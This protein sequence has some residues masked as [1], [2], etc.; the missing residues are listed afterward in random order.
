MIED[1]GSQVCCSVGND[2][3]NWGVHSTN[4]FVDNNNVIHTLATN[5][6]K[7]LRHCKYEPKSVE[8]STQF[9]QIQVY[10]SPSPREEYC[11]VSGDH[12]ELVYVTSGCASNVQV[13][14]F[15][16]MNQLVP[17]DTIMKIDKSAESHCSSFIMNNQHYI[18]TLDDLSNH[19]T[20]TIIS[21]DSF[22]KYKVVSTYDWPKAW[23]TVS[24]FP[25]GNKIFALYASRIGGHI[26]LCE[27]APNNVCN[28]LWIDEND[29]YFTNKSNKSYKTN[30][31]SC[32]S[33]VSSE[34]VLGNE[35]YVI[36]IFWSME[37]W[38]GY[39]KYFL[40]KHI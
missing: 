3:S 13:E 25:V 29:K 4:V 12:N 15:N 33:C 40:F 11:T 21:S 10:T 36:N 14:R 24:A 27:L 35:H 31:F 18:V 22:Y 1:K 9:S 5:S 28:Q 39:S 19:S 23:W 6:Y 26:K 16:V 30:M 7:Y 38:H 34:V 20:S 17:I 37:F 32:S 2:G 8:R